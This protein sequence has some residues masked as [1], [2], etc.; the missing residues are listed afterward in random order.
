MTHSMIFRFLSVLFLLSWGTSAFSQ[1]SISLGVR[2][3]LN[4][5]NVSVS[6]VDETLETSPRIVFGFGGVV[7]VGLSD[8]I[9]L[10]AEPRYMQKGT[11]ISSKQSFIFI[12][13]PSINVKVNVFE[14]PVSVKAKFN[15][16]TVKPYLFAGPAISYLL[17][18][19]SESQGR[20][21]DIKDQLRSTEFSMD[22]GAGVAYEI[23]PKTSLT[24]DLRYSLGLSKVNKPED[25][26][27]KSIYKSRDI[28]LLI[29]VLFTL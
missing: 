26:N 27:D 15:T 4:F 29:G 7:E 17:E 3:G 12:P 20:T 24:A 5:A 9:C 11:V 25:P 13:I 16:G 19:K 14:L 2:G 10:Q 1:G 22:F 23:S 21:K 8:R 6:N 28:K 18:A